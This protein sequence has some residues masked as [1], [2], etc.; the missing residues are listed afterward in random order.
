MLTV[1]EI[2]TQILGNNPSKFYVLGGKECGVKERYISLLHTH[3]GE[4]KECSTVNEVLSLMGKKHLVP[5]KPAVYVIRYD[6]TFVSSI[7]EEVAKRID[8]ANII[9][10]IVC[11]YEVDK[12]ITKLDKYL[13]KYTATIDAVSPQFVEKYLHQDFPGLPDRLIKAAVNMS[14]NYGQAKNICRSMSKVPVGPLF[15][16]SDADLAKLFGCH[17]YSSEVEIK[18]SIAGRQFKQLVELSERYP[19]DLDRLVYTILQ[20]MIDLDKAMDNPRSQSDLRDFVKLWT[21]EDVYYMFMNT[22]SELN[23]LRSLSSYQVENS[24]IYLFGLLKFQRI[25]SPEVMK[26]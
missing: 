1:Q 17:D 11:V 9:G 10:T 15:D 20:T 4:K 8:G 16:K 7:S 14:S 2:G 13:P 24:L 6:E 18:R 12:H 25:P 5:L 26:G 3:Y 22:Y 19:D 23:K 21:R